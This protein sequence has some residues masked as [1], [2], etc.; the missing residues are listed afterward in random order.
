M[1]VWS[2]DHTS[3]ILSSSLRMGLSYHK[4][5]QVKGAIP[6]AS[7]STPP[8]FLSDSGSPQNR[9]AN[10]KNA[11]TLSFLC[12]PFEPLSGKTHGQDRE[13]VPGD[14]VHRKFS[15][16]GIGVFTGRKIPLSEILWALQVLN[17]SEDIA[18]VLFENIGDSE[19]RG[20]DPVVDDL[21]FRCPEDFHE[22]NFEPMFIEVKIGHGA[23]KNGNGKFSRL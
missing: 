16:R 5:N 13:P 2:Y 1:K 19:G 23:I 14:K 12:S 7:G 10:R 22:L 3:C 17:A 4:V 21:E 20:H 11:Q 15:A 18:M 9:Q 6:K 8:S